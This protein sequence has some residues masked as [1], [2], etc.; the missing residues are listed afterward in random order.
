MRGNGY[1]SMSGRE[2]NGASMPATKSAKLIIEHNIH[3]LAVIPE[4]I[5][6]PQILNACFSTLSL[7]VELSTI[8]RSQ[9]KSCRVKR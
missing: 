1:I 7:C 8:Y 4:N 2:A 3:S 9:I 6:T 5:S